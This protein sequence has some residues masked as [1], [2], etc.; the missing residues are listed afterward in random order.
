[1]D[2]NDSRGK[3]HVREA[4]EAVSGMGLAQV[5]RTGGRKVTCIGPTKWSNTEVAAHVG[6]TM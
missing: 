4:G 5:S 1:M 6:E 3:C 2:Q